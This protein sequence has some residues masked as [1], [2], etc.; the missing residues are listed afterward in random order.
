[1]TLAELN[2]IEQIL[3]ENK[4]SKIRAS[5]VFKET[6]IKKYCKEG[7]SWWIEKMNITEKETYSNLYN[8]ANEATDIYESFTEHNWQ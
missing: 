1:M 3:K 4:E 2:K 5:T 8:E 7:D 6:M